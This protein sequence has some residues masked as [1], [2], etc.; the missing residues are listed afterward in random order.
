MTCVGYWNHKFFA[1]FLL[2]MGSLCISSTILMVFH[3]ALVLRDM[4]GDSSMTAV[5]V[6]PIIV[7]VLGILIG[8][9]VLSFGLVHLHYIACNQTTIDRELKVNIW[10]RGRYKNWTD[11]MGKSP[12]L[13]FLPIQTANGNGIEWVRRGMDGGGDGGGDRAEVADN[14][15]D[16]V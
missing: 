8:T 7:S 6:Q 13:W 14:N 12:L 2:H 10:D 5:W 9:G 16:L 4:V 15:N 11:R 1:L 3:L